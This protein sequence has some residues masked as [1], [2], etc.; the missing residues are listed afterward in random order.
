VALELYADLGRA[1]GLKQLW[2]CASLSEE[3]TAKRILPLIG[4]ERPL[5]GQIGPATDL[6][7]PWKTCQ[8]SVTGAKWGDA[9]RHV[10]EMLNLIGL[11]T[12]VVLYAMLLA[13]VVRAH[14]AARASFDP[15]L[16]ATAILG[17]VWNLCALA[18]YELPRTGVDG[19]FPWL[20]VIGFA[21][22]GFLP[23]V[24]VHSVLRGER[25][26]IPAATQTMVGIAYTVSAT[27]AILHLNNASQG[28]QVPSVLGMRVLTYTFVA[29]VVPLAALTRGQPGGRRALWGVALAAFTVSALH[30]SQ[31]HRG[32][33]SWPV[34]LLGHH[35]SVPL[36]IA[37]L[38][39]DYPFALADLFLKRA[40]TLLILVT[41]AFVAVTTLGFH[42]ATA[43]ALVRVD[44]GEVGILVS[45]WVATA[46][47]APAIRRGASWFVDTVVLRRP[48][49]GL[50]R[51]AVARQVQE[52]E[53]IPELLSDVCELLAPAMS[54]RTVTWHE[55]ALPLIE[56]SGSTTVHTG[57]EARAMVL[58][59]GGP[60]LSA[61]VR[62]TAIVLIHT[63]EAPRY[64][65]AISD[66]TRGR[67]FL[68]DDVAALEFIGVL[69]ARRIDAIR[70]TLERYQREL[71]EQQVAKLAAEAEL[72]ALRA[73]LNPHFLFNALT[74]IAQ[75]VE[76]APARA[77]VTIMRLTSL[78]RG[79]LRS[80]GEYTT[81]GRE[82]EIV[83]SYLEIEQARFEHR[84]RVTIAVPP[85]LRNLRVLP[86]LLQPI[87]ENAVKHG[88]APLAE[89][90]QV[91]VSS[92]L[93]PTRGGSSHLILTVEDS[94]AGATALEIAHGRALGVGLQNIERRLAYQYGGAASLRVD[95]ASGL[96]TTVTIRLPVNV[97][98]LAEATSEV[99]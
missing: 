39:Q 55:L 95:S 99:S 9:I 70:I 72:R 93:E 38:Y 31:L 27:A 41:A 42:A 5:V 26:R 75:L 58:G 74:T 30:L 94:G 79:V 77:L 85:H 56:T 15:L 11:S 97:V 7:F 76:E 52:R 90:G 22:L 46:L 64:A 21:A 16:V 34:E 98:F 28:V 82:L 78:L 60:G 2:K 50:L 63:A 32:D 23:A 66:L 4:H 89:G 25:Q 88:I 10:G 37:I 57:D 73:Q 3:V 86:L 8:R 20:S 81:L 62:P 84:L 13:M 67:R 18:I 71:R 45:L 54:A 53:S 65:I 43:H 68:S 6:F 87:V 48:D 49:F 24:V 1:L 36:A 40:L 96:G 35:A 92:R 51:T 47:A 17:L 69:V 83:E 44:P 33:A 91:A 59:T 14:H 19:P 61:P 12:G 29:S 80:E